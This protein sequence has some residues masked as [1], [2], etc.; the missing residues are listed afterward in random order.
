MS[1]EDTIGRTW[2]ADI[3][4]I[5]S[6]SI[7]M[8]VLATCSLIGGE[9]STTILF[10]QIC[11]KLSRLKCCAFV[12]TNSFINLNAIETVIQEAIT[13]ETYYAIKKSFIIL[14]QHFILLDFWHFFL[15]GFLYKNR[16]SVISDNG[17][18]YEGKNK[19]IFTVASNRHEPKE[20]SF[21]PAIP[22]LPLVP[23]RPR[24]AEIFMTIKEKLGVRTRESGFYFK[25]SSHRVCD[26]IES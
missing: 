9:C 19:D 24:K 3:I 15:Q 14:L 22:I 23:R 4:F 6:V 11:C 25:A 18:L 17:G 21:R 10:A 13:K 7:Q 12:I 5:I 26:S 16:P 8:P 20:Q 1:I 2:T